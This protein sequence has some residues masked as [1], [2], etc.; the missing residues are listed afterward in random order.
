MRFPTEV[1]M[2]SCQTARLLKRS[3]YHHYTFVSGAV[4]LRLYSAFLAYMAD[5]EYFPI[6]RAKTGLRLECFLR[7]FI[8]LPA[9]SCPG[10]FSPA[11][12]AGFFSPAICGCEQN[13]K[14]ALLEAQSNI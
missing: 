4:Y 8:L 11:F 3:I 7:F 1:T 2:K 14:H 13:N 10:F 6:P 12:W 9:F 5:R